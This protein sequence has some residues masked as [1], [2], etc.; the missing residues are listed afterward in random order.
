MSRIEP[1]SNTPNIRPTY[2]SG[3]IRGLE[4]HPLG[5]CFRSI[6][7]VP[8]IRCV[9]GGGSDAC[10][11]V[12][13]TR[14]VRP[15]TPPCSRRCIGASL[16][17]SDRRLLH[18]TF[19]I[20]AE[21]DHAGFVNALPMLHSRWMSAIESDGTDSLDELV[22]MSAYESKIG[23]SFSGD[24]ELRIG[25]SPV[26]ELARLQPREPPR[27]RIPARQVRCLPVCAAPV[28][29]IALVVAVPEVVTVLP[30]L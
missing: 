16:A 28:M 3:A 10:R 6:A 29:L 14:T 18:A 12:R 7:S 17:A 26:E 5:E 2:A 22:T 13:T 27:I 30:T 8:G 9:L 1:V 20:R 15:L 4:T 25:D 21:S 19:E 23:R 24:F 11:Q